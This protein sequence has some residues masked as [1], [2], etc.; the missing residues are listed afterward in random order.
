LRLC[1]GLDAD[2]AAAAVREPLLRHFGNPAPALIDSVLAVDDVSVDL[3]VLAFRRSLRGSGSGVPGRLG[4]A[5]RPPIL[6]M[7]AS[8]AA[9]LLLRVFGR[10]PGAEPPVRTNGRRPQGDHEQSESSIACAVDV[11]VH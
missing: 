3:Q 11:C 8:R 1:A 2:V 7:M 6:M 9:D 10:L 5:C 4:F